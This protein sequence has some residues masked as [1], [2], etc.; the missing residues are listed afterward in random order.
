MIENHKKTVY[1]YDKKYHFYMNL[2][3]HDIKQTKIKI[4]YTTKK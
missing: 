2:Y 3:H 1:R 4:N